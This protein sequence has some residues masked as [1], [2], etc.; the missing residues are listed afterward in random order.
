[1]RYKTK[2]T[3]SVAMLALSI[4]AMA[5]VL[6]WGAERAQY[7]LER[8]RLAHQ[9]YSGYL[10]LSAETFRLFK[11]IRR[12]LMDGEG[13]TKFDVELAKKRLLDR[14]GTIRSKIEAEREVGFR[15]G[16]QD[17][18][19]ARLAALT[20]QINI[21]LNEVAEVERLLRT[22]ERDNAV[23]LLSTT[24][25]DRVDRQI[26][27]II[28]AGLAD[29]L[30]EVM[31]AEAATNALAQQLRW[32]ALVAIISAASFA[33]IS[34]WLLLGRLRRPLEALVEGT[35]KIS[36]G[37]FSHNID[38]AGAD[39]FADLA[40]HFNAMAVQLGNQRS[41]IDDARR[42]LEKQVADRTVELRHA[43]EQLSQRDEMRSRL[44]ADISHELRTP[45]TAMRGLAE[46]ALRTRK[47][48]ESVYRGALGRIVDVSGQLTRLVND[49]FLIARSD[50][51]ALDMQ[52]AEVDLGA[53]VKAV[54][55]DMQ[56]LYE[57]AGATLR[58]ET[59][60]QPVTVAGDKE[61]LR[62]LLTILTDNALKHGTDD[63]EATIRLTASG[64]RCS[65]D[66]V[67]NGHGIEARE[68]GRVFDRFYRG[69]RSN[70]PSNMGGGLG[71][72]IAKSLV[73]AHGGEI[74]VKS[75][76][77]K[78]AVFTVSLPLINST[79]TTDGML[80]GQTEVA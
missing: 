18:E 6:Y 10:A 65:I 72:P 20:E 34:I 50:A 29:E 47:D 14:L 35:K 74:G 46:V 40:T 33:V 32:T 73:Q 77:G 51:G 19:T 38:V 17:D 1:M 27:A 80:S 67:D 69:N 7:N 12:D 59:P 25:E 4:V 28:D 8:S 57:K 11:R 44:F 16:E 30:E 39:E 23:T 76:L 31:D 64:G 70:K 48:H 22:G 5:A 36:D 54:V 75:E 79:G 52:K 71:L 66:V 24:L 61:R 63:V 49:L 2:V 26:G 41:A 45:I 78:G 9:E 68:L 13:Q 3:L 55:H 58:F 42:N 43:N 53:V 37:S 60:E 56:P 21:A 15:A 62:Q